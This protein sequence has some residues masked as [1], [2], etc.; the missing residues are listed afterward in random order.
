LF[1]FAR[2]FPA[3]VPC[4][5]FEFLADNQGAGYT[6]RKKKLVAET[7][8]AHALATWRR[9]MQEYMRAC[10]P[11]KG[12]KETAHVPRGDVFERVAYFL[13]LSSSR[14]SAAPIVQPT[15]HYSPLPTH[16]HIPTSPT[17]HTTQAYARTHAQTCANTTAPSHNRTY[18][19]TRM[20]VD[21]THSHYRLT[22]PYRENTLSVSLS[23]SLSE[24]LSRSLPCL[25]VS[26][27]VFHFSVHPFAHTTPAKGGGGASNKGDAV[28]E[29]A[30]PNAIKTPMP[31]AAQRYAMKADTSG[32]VESHGVDASVAV[33][34]QDSTHPISSHVPLPMK[35]CFGLVFVLMLLFLVGGLVAG[36]N[37]E[38]LKKSLE[39]SMNETETV[40]GVPIFTS[41]DA[42]NGFFSAGTVSV[43][44]FSSGSSLSVGMFSLGFVS[45]GTVSFGFFSVGIFSVGVF[46]VGI[47]SSGHIVLGLWAWG[48][49]AFYKK[50]GASM[51]RAKPIEVDYSRLPLQILE[52]PS[53]VKRINALSP[54]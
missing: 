27:C 3:A 47:V 23:L 11:D 5:R 8:C 1:V 2:Y 19:R 35:I 43:G 17:L 10:F 40:G 38:A 12:S 44:V 31:K 53:P 14:H 21:C 39:I 36:A 26:L 48:S 28:P 4:V 29:T 45:M 9:C 37:Q 41:G 18:N 22:R 46:S 16:P 49:Y 50:G 30:T 13:R 51:Y 20:L 33:S 42:S 7:L 54:S 6:K 15:L 34:I 52:P 25:V 24:T 32:V